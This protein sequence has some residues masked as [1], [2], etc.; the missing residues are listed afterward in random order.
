MAAA[1]STGLRA[2]DLFQRSGGGSG[3][4]RCQRRRPGHGTQAERISTCGWWHVG[5]R[6]A[7]YRRRRRRRRCAGKRLPWSQ[8]TALWYAGV[9]TRAKQVLCYASR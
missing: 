1:M 9:E 5:A 4:E 6:I 2:I 8:K 3:G 7:T